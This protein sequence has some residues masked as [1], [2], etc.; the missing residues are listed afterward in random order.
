MNTLED[1]L[2]CLGDKQLPV[3]DENGNLTENGAV[4][5]KRLNDIIHCL[6]VITGKISDIQENE[7]IKELDY[8]SSSRY[9]M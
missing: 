5:Y 3:F 8:I 2:R 1:I 7:I 6:S 4:S 9:I